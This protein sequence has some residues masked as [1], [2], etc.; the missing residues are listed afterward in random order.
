MD[1]KVR[2]LT[3]TLPEDSK[4][5]MKGDTTDPSLRDPAIIGHQFT[6]ETLQKL[7]IGRGGFLLPVEEV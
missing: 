2:L 6:D 3:T 7:K 1:L 4:E 5:R